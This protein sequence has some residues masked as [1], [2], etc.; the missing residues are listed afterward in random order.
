MSANNVDGVADLRTSGGSI[1]LENISAKMSARTSGGSIRADFLTL[2]DDIDLQTSG[3]SISIDIQDASDFNLDLRGNRVNTQLRNFTGEF[4][5]DHIEGRIGNG[6]PM[7]TA[8]TSG[9]AVNL[10]Y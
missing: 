10:D 5:R 7:I 8:R 4:E 1:Q 3:G 9:G 2:V 6:G